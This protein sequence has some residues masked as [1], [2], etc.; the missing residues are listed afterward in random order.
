MIGGGG[1][2]SVQYAQIKSANTKGGAFRRSISMVSGNRYCGT[3]SLALIVPTTLASAQAHASKGNID[4]WLFGLIAP[5]VV[6]GAFVT[7]QFMVFFSARFLVLAFVLFALYSAARLYRGHRERR[8]LRP[9]PGLIVITLKGVLGGALSSGLGLG[10]GF[11]AV[12]LLTRFVALP[13]AIGT[14]AALALPM[15]VVGTLSYLLAAT[16]QGCDG[17]CAGY[18]FLPAVA[19]IGISAVLAAPIGTWAARVVPASVVRRAF[20]LLLISAATH[21]AYN[22]FTLKMVVDETGRIV[23]TARRLVRPAVIVVQPAEAPAWIGDPVPAP[24]FALARRYGPQRSF[25][26]LLVDQGTDAPLTVRPLIT[27]L[28]HPRK[29]WL[30][31]VFTPADIERVSAKMV[32]RTEAQV[33][34]TAFVAAEGKTAGVA[35]PPPARLAH[36]PVAARPRAKRVN[37]EAGMP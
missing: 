7:S 21:L 22:T 15:A 3:T 33:E 35:K 17:R 26:L 1:R 31:A 14:A 36:R 19:A 20:A 8:A 27:D 24:Y 6:A 11:F 30:A 4:W 34:T 16:P 2:G 28:S 13:R 29:Y 10:A 9:Q 25:L 5:S 32:A 23:A 37:T 12:P 18:V